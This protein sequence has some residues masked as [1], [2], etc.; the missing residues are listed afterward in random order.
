MPHFSSLAQ[1]FLNRMYS[2]SL[3]L[4]ISGLG[5][6]STLKLSLESTCLLS[7]LK[8]Q[9]L[10]WEELG[11]VW[12]IVLPISPFW[13]SFGSFHSDFRKS[14]SLLHLENGDIIPMA[15]VHSK[16]LSWFSVAL[17]PEEKMHPTWDPHRERRKMLVTA[18]LPRSY[19]TLS[20]APDA[21]N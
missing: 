5:A 15:D 8:H 9:V 21:S 11:K 7:S 12:A 6:S 13:R 20:Q 17:G 4:I 18:N 3:V 16:M 19:L 1:W 2:S 10:F 14:V